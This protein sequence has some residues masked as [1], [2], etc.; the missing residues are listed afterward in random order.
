MLS[1]RTLVLIFSIVL[2][3]R[4]FHCIAT[5]ISLAALAVQPANSESLPLQN[6]DDADP[7]ESGCICQ[8][9]LVPPL[10]T[11]EAAGLTLPLACRLTVQTAADRPVVPVEPDI[12]RSYERYLLGPPPLGGKALR[13]WTHLLLI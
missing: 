8:G 11:A 7:N 10:V 1:R 9:A 12:G 6:P 2:I 3:A 4:T 5:G 13:V